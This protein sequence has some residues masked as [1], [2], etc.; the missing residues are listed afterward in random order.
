MSVGLPSL[1]LLLGSV[2]SFATAFRTSSD[3]TLSPARAALAEP[4]ARGLASL[5]YRSSL[6]CGPRLLARFSPDKTGAW[7]SREGVCLLILCDRP[8][9]SRSEGRGLRQGAAFLRSRAAASS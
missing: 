3:P 2:E 1:L 6:N 4:C 8:D 7:P 5:E 9:S